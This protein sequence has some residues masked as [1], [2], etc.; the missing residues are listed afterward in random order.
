MKVRHGGTYLNHKEY[1]QTKINICCWSKIKKK[2]KVVR[3][4]FSIAQ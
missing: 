4:P 2:S 1:K 3:H